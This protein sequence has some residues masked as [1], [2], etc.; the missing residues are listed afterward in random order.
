[1]IIFLKYLDRFNLI[2]LIRNWDW[3]E[4]LFL[5]DKFVQ[6]F[7][8]SYSK[9]VGNFCYLYGNISDIIFYTWENIA[10]DEVIV[11]DKL[12][13]PTVQKYNTYQLS[14]IDSFIGSLI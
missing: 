13:N 7:Y 11:F 10:E 1:M 12:N 9:E 5:T 4:I 6:F 8:D 14:N 2:V 3:R